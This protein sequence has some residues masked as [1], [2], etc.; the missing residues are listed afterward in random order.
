LLGDNGVGKTSLLC[1]LSQQ[2]QSNLTQDIIVNVKAVRLEKGVIA[3]I[4]DFSPEEIQSRFVRLF[5]NARSLYVVVLDAGKD[6]DNAKI[7]YWLSQI[8]ANSPDAPIVVVVNKTDL[9]DFDFDT[10]LFKEQY[11]IV[12]VVH[13]SG[14]TDDGIAELKQ[15]L[16]QQIK[17]LPYFEYPRPLSW[18][19]AMWAIDK[20]LAKKDSIEIVEFE[21]LCDGQ[22]VKNKH[23]QQKLLAVMSQTGL[24]TSFSGQPRLSSTI[25]IDPI[26]VVKM[27]RKILHSEFVD[28][29]G[30][31]EL[32]ML[33]KIFKD[34]KHFKPR[35]IDWLIELLEQFELAIIL[36]KGQRLL[37]PSR[38]VGGQQSE[39][40]NT[41]GKIRFRLHYQGYV[42]NQVI[43]LL[44]NE[45]S[46]INLNDRVYW[47]TGVS[48][49]VDG[50]IAKIQI[51]EDCRSIDIWATSNEFLLKVRQWLTDINKQYYKAVEQIVIC[52]E[53]QSLTYV[54]IDKLLL[55]EQQGERFYTPDYSGGIIGASMLIAELLFDYRLEPYVSKYNFHVLNYQGIKQI[56]VDLPMDASW[57]FLTGHNGFGKTNILQAIA[58]AVRCTNIS[59]AQ[60]RAKIALSVDGQL[61]E[62]SF[63]GL[64][65]LKSPRRILGYGASRLDMGSDRNTKQYESYA[66]LF[67]S[68]V[69]LRN[70]EREGL[71]RWYF[72]DAHKPKFHDCVEKFKQ[73]IPNLH[74]IEVDNDS[75]VWYIEKDDQGNPLPKVQ[76]NALATGYQNIIAMV[77]DIILNLAEPR[78][79]HEDIALTDNMQAIVLIDELEL[80][81][82]PSWQKRLPQLLTDMF[83]NV[84]FI[85][86]THSPMPILGAPANS[87]VFTVNRT[88]HEGI[89]MRRYDDEIDTSRLLPNSLLTSPIFDMPD[90]TA[91]NNSAGDYTYTQDNFEKIKALQEME[92]RIA[93]FDNEAAELAAIARYESDEGEGEL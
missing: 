10:T 52:N 13:T 55:S 53:N 82:H 14:V 60:P 81:L 17:K 32:S 36:G 28:N 4:W 92:E 33:S 88:A 15:T 49:A 27:A 21:E 9:S 58:L 29:A 93:G 34:A 6:K 89:T 30:L 1:R 64:N 5:L 46:S 90:I 45:F 61:C 8:K 79:K 63:N 65:F 78:K 57:I 47:G 87:A 77:G 70:I 67:E 56:E 24:V 59:A 71:S 25:I 35:H 73:L 85:A 20:Q 11:K 19:A 38:V 51:S 69:L 43:A 86:S 72:I 76:F 66:S 37:I 48:V 62:V 39:Q 42:D 41:T 84:L 50:G 68:Q 18:Q 23:L 44:C 54:D 26:W 75:N 40:D 80:Y 3:R 7:H 16:I 31:L 22:G 74:D 83:P 91:S 2:E 12:G